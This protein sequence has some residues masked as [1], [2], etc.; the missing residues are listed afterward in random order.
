MKTK[1]TLLS[2]ALLLAGCGGSGGDSASSTSL[3]TYDLS[4]NITTANVPASA[5]VCVDANQ[6]YRCDASEASTIARNGAF[7][8]TSTSLSIYDFPILA[9]MDT[10]V[11]QASALSSV[12]PV[13]AGSQTVLAA[14]NRRMKSDNVINGITTLISGAM[15]NGL[16]LTQAVSQ[17]ETEIKRANIALSGSLLNNLNANELSVLEANVVKLS[18]AAGDKNRSS[19]LA[20][21]GLSLAD[22]K[23]L[24]EANA[25]A[26]DLTK[27]VTELSKAKFTLQPLNDTGLTK[28]FSDASNTE[29][30]TENPS[31]YPGQDAMYGLDVT[32]KQ[33]NT[34]NGFKFKKLDAQGNELADD[35]TEWSC[36]SDE[37][38][39]LIWEVKSTDTSSI[40]HLDRLFALE[41]KDRFKPHSYDV[42][43][44]NCQASGDGICTTQQYVDE[45]N[46]QKICG[47]ST[48]R[49]PT[50]HELYDIVDF[51]EEGKLPDGSIAG[52]SL[53]YFPNQ[54]IGTE[55][56]YPYIKK[57]IVWTDHFLHGNFYSEVK[58]KLYFYAVHLNGTDPSDLGSGAVTLT[59]G[60]S[61]QYEIWTNEYA[62]LEWE[63]ESYSFPTRLVATKETK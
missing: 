17:V 16:T 58:G 37:R 10:G 20:S 6:N 56:D 1:L 2:A 54:T 59:R 13:S 39:G 46:K 47:L 60:Q 52:L 31:D 36:V 29:N 14:P 49:L 55:D 51:G 18:Q 62:Q 40:Q 9:V 25:S 12:N 27:A 19:V 35:A 61:A 24:T 48:W 34:G 8:I 44:V 38:T 15:D 53:K 22:Y 3:P 23:A 11:A 57:G 32:D 43:L 30:Q 33:A 41:I 63:T 5:K 42:S 45:I 7:T 4:G 26:E 21:A 28:F 50:G